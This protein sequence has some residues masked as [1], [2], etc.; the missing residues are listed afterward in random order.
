MMV[1]KT[2]KFSVKQHFNNLTDFIEIWA[3]QLFIRIVDLL[4]SKENFY[5]SDM[6]NRLQSIHTKEKTN[7]APWSTGRHTAAIV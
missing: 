3:Y 7:L 1:T 6:H 2:E 5:S 4:W